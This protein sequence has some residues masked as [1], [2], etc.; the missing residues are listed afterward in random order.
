MQTTPLSG[1]V[2]LGGRDARPAMTVWGVAS[3]LYLRERIARDIVPH[4]HCTAT[5]L[6]ILA[7]QGIE[8]VISQDHSGGSA[9]DI[10]FFAVWAAEKSGKMSDG[11]SSEAPTAAVG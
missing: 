2:F 11:E 6:S 4:D 5:M 10:G 7:L 1:V 9:V 3:T 8:W